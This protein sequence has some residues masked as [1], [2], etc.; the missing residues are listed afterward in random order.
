V[1]PLRRSSPSPAPDL[2]VLGA[3]DPA[4]IRRI[5]L[6]TLECVRRRYFRAELEGGEHVPASGPCIIVGNHSGGPLMPDALV[7]ASYWWS[8]AGVERP[9]YAMVHDTGLAIPG[10]GTILL[11]M[12]A[13]RA[14]WENALKVLQSG[15]ALLVYPGGELDCLRSFWRRH[16]IDFRG[17]TGFIRLA[18][19]EGVPIVP[20]VNVGGH[21]V[22]VTLLSSERLA[23]W[24]GMARFARV[25]TVPLNLGLPW[26]VW[27][28]GLLP[29]WPLPAKLVYRIGRPIFLGRDPEAAE[30]DRV[31]RLAYDYVTRRM[32][33]MLDHLAA[34]RRL[35][36]LG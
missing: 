16:R 29:Y 34:R 20:V 27:L 25:K 5:A 6:P 9:A 28:T 17:R 2:S 4:F 8:L 7:L 23:T 31:V 22:Y 13:L 15:A 10:I 24:T 33:R 3:R 1:L 18:L 26:G 36:V 21:E 12:G 30:D 14:S 11:K 32:Q 19:T 35:P